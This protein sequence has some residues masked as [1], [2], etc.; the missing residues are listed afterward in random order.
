LILQLVRTNVNV[1]EYERH[2][3]LG[4]DIN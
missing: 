3:A 1:N 4:M 2:P